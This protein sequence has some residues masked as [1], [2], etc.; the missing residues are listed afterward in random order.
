VA[1]AVI[2]TLSST[3]HACF[4]ASSATDLVVDVNGWFA[5]G[6]G[7]N[8]VAPARVLDTRAGETGMLNV[9][10]AKLGGGN[11]VDVQL[12]NIYG[13]DTAGKVAAVSLNVTVDNTQGSGFVTVFPCGTTPL[14]SSVN[15]IAGQVVANAVIAPVSSTGHV[16]F[17]A[18]SPTDLIVDVNGWFAAASTGPV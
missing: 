13:A 2:A 12:D 1:N 9:G 3:G 5:A 8:S 7:Y 6:S 18:S 10:K 11:I 15:F 17:F 16:C 4:F 14:V